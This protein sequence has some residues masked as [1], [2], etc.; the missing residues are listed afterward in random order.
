MTTVSIGE[1]ARRTGVAATALRDYEDAGVLPPAARVHGRRR[2]DASAIRRIELLRFAQRA[3]F[4]LSEVKA[5][6]CS[7]ESGA[8]LHASWAPIA[9]AKLDELAAL[10]ARIRRMRRDVRRALRCRCKRIEDCTLGEN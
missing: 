4:T 3:G 10:G 9:R 8:A 2:Y 5:T 1:A 7:V 6:F